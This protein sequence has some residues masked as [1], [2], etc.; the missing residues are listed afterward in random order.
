MAYPG[1][2]PTTGGGLIVY[3]GCYTTPDR[4]GHGEGIS[5][6][7]M[8]ADSGDWQALGIVARVANPS[9]L[10]LHPDRPVLYCVH[11]GEMSE[12][13][14]F[15]IDAPSVTHLG[16]WPSGG[17]NP[18]HLDFA[19]NARW[20]VVANYTGATIAALPVALDG[21]LGSATD[22]VTL[23]GPLGP[24]PVQQS[25]PHPHDIPFDPSGSFVAVPD[26]GL[27]RLFIFQFDA[28]RGRFQA[29]TPPFAAAEAGAGPRHI[30][31]HPA[32]RWAYVIN[33]L[34]STITAYAYEHAGNG[35]APFQ[36]LSSVPDDIAVRNTGSEIV[37][38]PSGRFVYVSNRG[39]DSVGV[40]EVEPAGGR[41]RPVTWCLS[42]GS[43][44]RAIALD[45]TG[46][47]LY[48]ANQA[49]DSIVSFHVDA[50]SGR[51]I[52]TGWT[53]ATGSPSS[54]VFFG[55]VGVEN[56]GESSG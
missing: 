38:H 55:P 16:T 30:A 1:V 24:D 31:F 43:T 34:N 27:D 48:A 12:V 15:A 5:A 46:K 8:D 32:R 20:I 35:M 40:F 53:V 52:P 54:M 36:T 3:V 2:M 39:H 44:P 47:F 18:V 4:S 10:A 17:L 50:A 22:V 26:K 14:A 25:S 19:P 11:G 37:V 45:P 28:E 13:S 23:T 21:K 51:L 56:S 33:E 29:A 6:F 7:R 9:Y 41:L 42:G 49:S